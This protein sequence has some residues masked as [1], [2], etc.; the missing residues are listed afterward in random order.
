MVDLK[1]KM[2]SALVLLS[3]VGCALA[4]PPVTRSRSDIESFK[5][6]LERSRRGLCSLFNLMILM[7][8]A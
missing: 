4:G 5:A 8:F 6:F 3:V 1:R 7:P 2:W